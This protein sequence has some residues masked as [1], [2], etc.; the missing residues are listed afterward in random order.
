MC[1]ICQ[2]VFFIKVGVEDAI[3]AAHINTLG[4]ILLD[5]LFGGG[6]ELPNMFWQSP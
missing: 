3:P 4:V 6:G 1:N 5:L 2:W